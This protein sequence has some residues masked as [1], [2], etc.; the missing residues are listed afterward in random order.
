MDEVKTDGVETPTEANIATT[1]SDEEAAEEK[2]DDVQEASD[3][4]KENDEQ[5]E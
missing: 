2:K 1:L 5:K 4:V 3:A